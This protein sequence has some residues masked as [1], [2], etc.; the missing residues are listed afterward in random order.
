MDFPLG[1]TL[2]YRPYYCAKKKLLVKEVPLI[3]KNLNGGT[4]PP[5]ILKSSDR[6]GPHEDPTDKEV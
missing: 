2:F 3:F 4:F 6:K 1:L 5:F